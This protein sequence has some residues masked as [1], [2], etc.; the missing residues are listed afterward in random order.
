M[1]NKLTIKE[2]N[3]MKVGTGVICAVYH[4]GQP[5]P[6]YPSVNPNC[7]V[8]GSQPS[9]KENNCILENENCVS[10]WLKQPCPHFKPQQTSRGICPRCKEEIELSTWH[11]CKKIEQDGSWERKFDELYPDGIGNADNQWVSLSPTAKVIIKS[12]IKSLLKEQEERIR[13]E[14]K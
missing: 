3:C 12:F 9:E 1:K 13:R 14:G 10:N 6:G 11:R 4:N 7:P 5:C 2:C 8:H